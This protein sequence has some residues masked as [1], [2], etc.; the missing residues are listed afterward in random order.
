MDFFPEDLWAMVPARLPLKIFTGF[1]LVCKQWKSIVE[2]PF[3]RGSFYIRPPKRGLCF[4]VAHVQ[5]F[6]EIVAQ[7]QCDIWELEQS[8]GSFIESFLTDKSHK[9]KNRIAK[10]SRGFL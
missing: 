7:Y 6:L 10:L 5:I 1:K 3:F 9:D 4:I 2:T 8:L